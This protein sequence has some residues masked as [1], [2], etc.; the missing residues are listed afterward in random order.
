MDC[1]LITNTG[2]VVYTTAIYTTKYILRE[3]ATTRGS[4]PTQGM[5]SASF[6]RQRETEA[7]G[8]GVRGIGEIPYRRFAPQRARRERQGGDKRRIGY[9]A[10]GTSYRINVARPGHKPH[11]S[12]TCLIP[13]GIRERLQ[14]CRNPRHARYFIAVSRH[15]TAASTGRCRSLD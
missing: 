13:T 7:N 6:V 10:D 8:R 5:K 15:H 2:I 3:P 12:Y 14:S 4:S 1:T 11:I 9:A